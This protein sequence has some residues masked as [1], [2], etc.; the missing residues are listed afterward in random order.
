MLDEAL[1]VVTALWTGEPVDHDG[2]HYRART[3]AG[4]RPTPVQQPRI[5]IWV[6]GTWPARPAFRRAARYDGLFPTFRDLDAPDNVDPALLAEAVAYATSTASPALPPLEVAIEG[7]SPSQVAAG[8]VRRRR[9]H[10]VGGDDRLV[11][12]HAGGDAPAHGDRSARPEQ[13]TRSVARVRLGED[14]V[15]LLQVARGR[16]EARPRR[17]GDGVCSVGVARLRV[18]LRRSRPGSG[19]GS[20]GRNL[21]SSLGPRQGPGLRRPARRRRS[22][23]ATTREASGGFEVSGSPVP[24]PYVVR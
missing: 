15:R 6:A 5:P 22:S 23:P 24:V 18:R 11:P 2:P 16:A 14:V 1:D 4:F 9:P 8:G 13:A 19:R 3:A 17:R 21:Y 12:R 10:L 7:A 20:A